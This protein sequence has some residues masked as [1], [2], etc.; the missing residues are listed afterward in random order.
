LL[1]SWRYGIWR[2]GFVGLSPL[3]VILGEQSIGLEDDWKARAANA[4][5]CAST[6]YEEH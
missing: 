2:S 4:I 6:P 1:K 3:H 5:H